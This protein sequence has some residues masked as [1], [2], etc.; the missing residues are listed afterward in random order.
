L[1]LE[2]IHDISKAGCAL[3][4]DYFHGEEAAYP[5]VIKYAAD[6]DIW[7]F[8]YKETTAYC[9]GVSLLPDINKPGS[10][11]WKA[12]LKDNEMTEQLI[13]YGQV[14][15]RKIEED[16]LWHNRL[17]IHLVKQGDE[18]FILTN[19]TNMI[20][21]VAQSIVDTFK[22]EKVLL[23]D[24]SKG[25]V[26]L[27]GRGKGVRTFFNGLLRGHEDACG[28]VLPLDEG[29]EFLRNLYNMSRRVTP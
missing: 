12:L 11:L 14:I 23:W 15:E 8:E 27:H 20:S 6:R 21:E 2:G 5:D 19:C 17:R 7:T 25:M 10:D 16:N 26:S 28:G 3:T 13:E 18:E 29:F 22:V 4:W 9:H 1:G 24:V